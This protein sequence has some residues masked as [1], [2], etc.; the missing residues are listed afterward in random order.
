[1]NKNSV[2]L[3]LT[4]PVIFLRTGS[5]SS[6]QSRRRRAGRAEYPP[7]LLRGLLTLKI[8]KPTRIKSIDVIL[9]GSARTDWPDAGNGIAARRME[10]AEEKVFLH[11]KI[12][13]F[14][15][16]QQKRSRTVG[17]GSLL[18]ERRPYPAQSTSPTTEVGAEVEQARGRTSR[19]EISDSQ[20]PH[21]PPLTTFNS[22]DEHLPVIGERTGEQGLDPDSQRPGMSSDSVLVGSSMP[23]PRESPPQYS[24]VAPTK[25][26]TTVDSTLD[27]ARRRRSARLSLSGMLQDV[28]EIVQK[29]PNRHNVESESILISSPVERQETCDEVPD[30]RGRS[31]A[32]KD[33]GAL[34]RLGEALGIDMDDDGDTDDD[35]TSWKEFKPGTYH[36]P[37]S[38]SL[39][40]DLPPSIAADYAYVQYKLKAYV[41]RP[42]TFTSKLSTFT[43]VELISAPA[44]DNAEGDAVIIERQWDMELRYLISTSGRNFPQGSEI[45]WHIQLMPLSK[46][47]LHR[48]TFVLEEKTEYTVNSLTRTE[49]V[50]RFQLL[51]IRHPQ[52]LSNLKTVAR[53]APPLLPILPQSSMDNSSEAVLLP[54]ADPP[55]TLLSESSA[56]EHQAEALAHLLNVDGPWHLTGMLKVPLLYLHV[57]HKHPTSFVTLKHSLK[58]FLRVERG[59]DDVDPKTGR[60][61]QFDIIIETPINVLSKYTRSDWASLPPYEAL[62]PL[63]PS[64]HD[65]PQEVPTVSRESSRSDLAA[66]PL[67]PVVS[68]AHP[69][70][71]PSPVFHPHPLTPLSLSPNTTRTAE[72]PR[73]SSAGPSTP[74]DAIEDAQRDS[75][76]FAAHRFASL[77]AG[78]E[79][80]GGQFPPTYFAATGTPGTT[81]QS[82]PLS[83]CTT[84]HSSS[85]LPQLV[86]SGRGS[87]RGQSAR[88][89][90]TRGTTPSNSRNAS[91]NPSR[92]RDNGSRNSSRGPDRGPPALFQIV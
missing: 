18:D 1:M 23:E 89:Q 35:D 43:M 61:K 5:D 73:P 4:E 29:H 28:R 68:P 72:S 74:N 64:E 24:S 45:P 50:R 21:R 88:R 60:K 33:K 79:D 52:S 10:I 14:H 7:A 49:P 39:P 2:S 70:R 25:R 37:I 90:A 59:E 44:E 77:M 54:Y 84:M 63:P 30:R 47:K 46:M 65:L 6:S 16:E 91:R 78:F 71:P 69:S 26:P 34:A 58:I 9:E 40:S 86:G 56:S 15:A 20:G 13:L 11:S 75:R 17:P 83:P 66:M 62:E 27:R 8:V 41:H 81:A 31:R 48:I 57:S 67:S 32:R 3:Q 53:N 92:V 22:W 85:Q 76:V 51:C 55:P 82:A 12:V 80:E 87:P 42:G 36:Y 38:F 19:R